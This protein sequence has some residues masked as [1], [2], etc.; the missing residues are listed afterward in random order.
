MWPT[1]FLVFINDLP[2]E[3][4]SRRRIYTDDSTLYSILGKSGLFEK[5]ESAD[6][7]EFDL[8]SIV[9]W[10]DKWLVTFNANKTKLLSFNRHREPLLVP[11][12]MNRIE[13]PEETSLRLHGLTFTRSMDWKP[14]IQS[15]AKVASRK[16]GFLEPS[17]SLLL[18][19]SCIY[20]NLPFVHVWSTVPISC[21]M[22]L[23]C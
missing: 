3:V 20:T 16:M 7:L 9:E 17:V 14:Y 22:G 13:L 18:N 15:I 11:V 4:Q 2:N 10:G 8:R 23:I 1:L 19:P 6:E 21:P 12:E 5:V